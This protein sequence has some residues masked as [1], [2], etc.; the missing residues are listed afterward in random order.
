MHMV[1]GLTLQNKR[2]FICFGF[3][4]ADPLFSQ[5]FTMNIPYKNNATKVL[6]GIDAMKTWVKIIQSVNKTAS[7]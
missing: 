1:Y 7:S 3:K 2:E 4:I 6:I 5:A